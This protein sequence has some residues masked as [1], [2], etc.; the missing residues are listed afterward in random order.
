MNNIQY[1]DLYVVASPRGLVDNVPDYII[2]MS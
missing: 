2:V 1:I